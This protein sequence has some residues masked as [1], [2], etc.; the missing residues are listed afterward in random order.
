AVCK[1]YCSDNGNSGP[2]FQ[3]PSVTP[4][5]VTGMHWARQPNN[6]ADATCGCIVRSVDG[7]VGKFWT[8]V[9]WCSTECSAGS[10]TN[11]GSTTPE[12][13]TNIGELW[14]VAHGCP[15]N[16]HTEVCVRAR[17]FFQTP[18][19]TPYPT[20]SPT[21]TPPTPSPTLSPTT[22]SP[23]PSPP[24]PSPTPYPPDPSGGC[25]KWDLSGWYAGTYTT[26]LQPWSSPNG[27]AWAWA[28]C[29]AACAMSATC[30]FWTL[31]LNGNQNCLLMSNIGDYKDVGGHYS[32]VKM[33]GCAPTPSPT[34]NPAPS[35]APSPTPGP[36]PSPPTLSPTTST[37]P[38][39]TLSPTTPS[40]TPSPPTLSPTTSPTPS[41]TLSP[42]TP[43][44]TP[45][46]PTLSPTTSPTPSPTLSPTTPSPTPSP[47][48]LSPTTSPTPS[49]TLSPT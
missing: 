9:L 18:S 45:S 41:P 39:P 37:T 13:P 21:P 43:S 1:T 27:N 11:F 15:R 2:M 20:S 17:Y 31:H 48:T 6:N 4:A 33:T 14:Y 25:Q 12:S 49:P 40:P 38:S 28:Q 3:A 46:P 34:P 47:P 32:G 44:P 8:S 5:G 22:P 24:T 30:E 29:A 26:V 10:E 35:P 42:K 19:P 7:G 36:T 16:G 23:T